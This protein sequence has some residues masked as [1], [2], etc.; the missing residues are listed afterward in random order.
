MYEVQPPGRPVGVRPAAQEIPYE[1]FALTLEAG[2]ERERQQRPAV[3]AGLVRIRGVA[4][5]VLHSLTLGE[6]IVRR[7]RRRRVVE[8]AHLPLPN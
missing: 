8:Y 6:D 1:V 2:H 7:R 5:V 4:N 3:L